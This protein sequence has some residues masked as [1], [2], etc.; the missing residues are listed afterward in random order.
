MLSPITP[1]AGGIC[2]FGKQMTASPATPQSWERSSPKALERKRTARKDSLDQRRQL[3]KDTRGDTI[4]SLPGQQ[5]GCSSL[6]T[7]PV[8][9]S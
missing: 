8:L 2:P 9:W 4:Q 5:E 7:L 6:A 3:G 1:E